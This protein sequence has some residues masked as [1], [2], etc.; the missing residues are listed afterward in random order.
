[1]NSV[2]VSLWAIDASAAVSVALHHSQVTLDRLPSG[3]LRE[4]FTAIPTRGWIFDRV[5]FPT[6]FASVTVTFTPLEP[7]LPLLSATDTVTSYTLS[8]SASPGASKL[9]AALKVSSP[10]VASNANLP[11]SG[12]PTFHESSSTVP[13]TSGAPGWASSTV[14]RTGCYVAVLCERHLSRIEGHSRRLVHVEDRDLH[15][16]DGAG[17]SK[18]LIQPR[19]VVVVLY[20]CVCV[21]GYA[22]RVRGLNRDEVDVVS[23]ADAP[24]PRPL[25]VQRC[26]RHQLA[27]GPVD[28]EVA[29]VGGVGVRRGRR[30][31]LKYRSKCRR[32]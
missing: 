15:F 4:A 3:S 22:A 12:P 2:T 32:L 9:G 13:S 29:A 26:L 25:E 7:R 18:R 21:C 11:P 17:R 27:R 24:V 31:R 19:S 16:P 23:G 10:L 5:T 8:L 28:G 6:S 1:M 14:A 30:R 20:Y